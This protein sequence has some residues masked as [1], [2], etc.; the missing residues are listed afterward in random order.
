MF[1]TSSS[2]ELASSALVSNKLQPKF[3]IFTSKVH[4]NNADKLEWFIKFVIISFPWK[5]G[6]ACL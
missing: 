2:K 5:K 1:S 6:L 3:G 4:Q